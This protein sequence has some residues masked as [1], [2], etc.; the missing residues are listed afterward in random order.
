M[1]CFLKAELLCCGLLELKC[2]RAALLMKTINIEKI[3]NK[4]QTQNSELFSIIKTYAQLGHPSDCDF[5]PRNAT[6][7]HFVLNNQ[8]VN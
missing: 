3:E 2:A 1:S 7:S 6:K 5:T 8:S 4:H